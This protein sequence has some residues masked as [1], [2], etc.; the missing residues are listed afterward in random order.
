MLFF[1]QTNMIE[2]KTDGLYKVLAPLFPTAKVI[3]IDE[4]S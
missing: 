1:F 3:G 4:M 2:D